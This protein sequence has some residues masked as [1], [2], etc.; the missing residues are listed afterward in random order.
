MI[1]VNDGKVEIDAT[2][3]EVKVFLSSLYEEIYNRGG[4]DLFQHIIIDSL[5]LFKQNKNKEYLKN[6]LDESFEKE[7][8]EKL[9]KLI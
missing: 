8:A 7:I 5:N 4:K 2:V 6:L 1:S 9:I 3:K